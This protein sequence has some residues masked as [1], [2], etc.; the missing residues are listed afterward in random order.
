MGVLY[1]LLVSRQAAKK[2]RVIDTIL[3]GLFAIDE[4]HGNLAVKLSAE[5]V[6]GVDVDFAPREGAVG[7]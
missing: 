4:D 2:F 5:I 7:L 3:E 6:I 1:S